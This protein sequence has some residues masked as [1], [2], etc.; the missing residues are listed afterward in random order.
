MHLKEKQKIREIFSIPKPYYKNEH[1][2]TYP[3]GEQ[4]YQGKGD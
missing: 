4:I 2:M 1:F 3:A